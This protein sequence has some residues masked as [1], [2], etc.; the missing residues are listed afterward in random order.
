MLTTQL[1]PALLELPG[2]GALTAAKII[3]ETAGVDRFKSRDA[4]ARYNGTAPLPVWSSNKAR[5]RLSRTG[6][7]QLNAALHRIALTQA[8]WHPPAKA[9]IERREERREQRTRG[10]RILKRRLSDAVFQASLHDE[11]DG[12]H[13]RRLTEEQV[14]TSRGPANGF[15]SANRSRRSADLLLAA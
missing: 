14:T 10:V 5:R 12:L 7:R 1:A 13:P 6:N 4:Y 15:G 3:D 8:R 11:T 9:M 2:C